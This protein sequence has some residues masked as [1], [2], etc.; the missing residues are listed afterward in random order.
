MRTA[1]LSALFISLMFLVVRSISSVLP[2]YPPSL[3]IVGHLLLPAQCTE[4]TV[5][6]TD[7]TMIAFL[8]EHYVVDSLLPVRHDSDFGF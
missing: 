3:D 2:V 7:A 1:A 5:V 6:D 4:F 8:T